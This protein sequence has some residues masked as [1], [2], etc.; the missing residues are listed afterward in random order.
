ML[1]PTRISRLEQVLFSVSDRWHNNSEIVFYPLPIAQCP[2]P[3]AQ[4]PDFVAFTTA[5]WSILAVRAL[6]RLDTCC[7]RTLTI[8]GRKA[9]SLIE[10]STHGRC[11]MQ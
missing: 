11:C 3:S 8:E 9:R 5:E 1:L 10:R 4:C 2:V 6:E 7:R